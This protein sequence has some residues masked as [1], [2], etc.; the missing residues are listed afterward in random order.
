[1]VAVYI[2]EASQVLSSAGLSLRAYG[3]GGQALGAMS[4]EG[5][6]EIISPFP[7]YL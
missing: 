1:M 7:W 2:E 4:R 6:T 3:D 5:M